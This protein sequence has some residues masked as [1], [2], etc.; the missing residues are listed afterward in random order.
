MAEGDTVRAIEV[1]DRGVEE[2]PFSQIRHS[3]GLTPPVIEAYYLAGATEKANE[4]L[5]DYVRVLEENITYMMRFTGRNGELVKNKLD[6]NLYILSDLY[7]MADEFGQ[8]EIA[9]GIRNYFST[10]G[11]K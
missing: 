7:G 1:L 2:L 10:L 9:N 6:E 5:N 11:L 3:Y 8:T 4:I